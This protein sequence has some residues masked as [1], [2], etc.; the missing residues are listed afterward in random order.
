LVRSESVT[1]E[2]SAR[3]MAQLHVANLRTWGNNEFA[4]QAF[5]R[6]ELDQL[7]NELDLIAS[8]REEAGVVYNTAKQIIAQLK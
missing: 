7:E 6:H 2:K 8:G 5:D 1:L 3:D 4:T